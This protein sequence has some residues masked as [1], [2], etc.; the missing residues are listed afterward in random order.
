MN[1]ELE[2]HFFDKDNNSVIVKA[3][4]DGWQILYA[5]GNSKTVENEATTAENLDAAIAE[6]N[7]T[8][9]LRDVEVGE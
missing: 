8:V 5:D 3:G 2:R 4:T 1:V 6:A 9:G 7:E